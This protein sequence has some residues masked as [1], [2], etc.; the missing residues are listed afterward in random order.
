M[1]QPKTYILDDLP[2]DADAL[3]FKPYVETLVDVCKTASTPLTIGVFGTWGSG[4]TSLMG[5]V[6][7][8]LPKNFTAAWFDAWK[9]DKEETLWRAFLLSVLFAVRRKVKDGESTEDLDYLETMLYR[10]IDIER[11][12][13]VTIDLGK[14]GGKVTQGVVQLGLSFIPGGSVLSE[15]VKKVQ[16]LGAESLTDDLTDA[17]QRERTKI[18]IEHVR[19]LEQFQDKFRS[20]VEQHVTNNGGRLVVFV[21][22]L[23]RCLPE[24]AIEVLEA[25]K[26]FVDASGCVFVLGLDQDVIARGIEMK[27]KE[28]GEKKD[29]EGKGRFTIEGIRYLEKII[30][31]PFQIPPVEQTD[32]GEFVDGLTADWPHADCPKVFAAGLGENPRQIKRTVNVFL[33]LWNLA[34]KRKEKLEGRIKPIR[35]AKVVAIQAIYPELYDLLK[36]TPRYLRE[37]EKYY[38][39]D[40]IPVESLPNDILGRIADGEFTD[41]DDFRKENLYKSQQE[42][43][44][45]LA[46]FVSR[47][48]I[49]R[50]LILHEPEF[51]EANFE[52]LKPDEL[53][54]Y[55]T[56][57]RRA[58]APKV[59][60]LE[61]PRQA[62]EPQ[63]VR[64]PAGKFLMGSSPEQ[65][66]QAIKD[67]A[68][69]S[70]V[71]WEHPQHEVELS[72]YSIGKYPVTNREYQAFVKDAGYKSPR[73]WDGEQYPAE[74]GDYPVVNVSW[75]DTVAFCNFLSQKTKKSY[76]LPT[77]AE[78]EKAARGEDGR[79]WPWGNEF[80]EKNTNTSEAR[81]GNTTP[82]GQFSPQGDSPYGCADMIGNIWE[83]CADWFD[84]NEYKNRK[85]QQ[86]K[87]P[88]GPQKGDTHVLR[89]GSCDD[90]RWDARC[91]ARNGFDPDIFGGNGGFRVSVSPINL[92][93]A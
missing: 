54:L 20:L 74:K 13:G 6:Q 15:F 41:E 59:E 17:I 51:Q 48:A 25:I 81:V 26:L 39:V 11:A 70:S 16:Q 46:N 21:D 88:Q 18:H 68:D 37:L 35:L 71:E 58:E 79:I 62:F 80:G 73:G 67:G 24:K 89:G 53:R 72:E 8:G 3:D 91:A 23:D 42:P 61:T 36:E 86:V 84:K 19:F 60:P 87:D 78:W 55:F 12:G 52:D 90:K 45:A 85:D 83:W 47:L 1:P 63:M 43:P 2:T 7:R 49:R 75:E 44:P 28:L 92:F 10:A 82:I 32:L 66:A 93:D 14:L 33:M 56:L 69:T 5:M 27:Y 34:E 57:T 31:L 76:R 50:I 65:A 9:Y 40:S 4:K 30:Q 38:R 64:I 29:G 22:D 77:E